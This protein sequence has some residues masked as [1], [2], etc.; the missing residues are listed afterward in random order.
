MDRCTC[1]C[2]C[3]VIEL[4]YFPLYITLQYTV[5]TI[6]WGH[7]HF[8][9]QIHIPSLAIQIQIGSLHITIKS[10]TELYI[11]TALVDFNSNRYTARITRR[12]RHTNSF[13]ILLYTY[14][15]IIHVQYYL[16]VHIRRIDAITTSDLVDLFPRVGYTLSF[17]GY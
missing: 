12:L 7:L 15:C 5:Y 2:S 9:L 1:S 3:C 16:S 11:D 6:V 8:A 14:I 13:S 4:F 17:A 10:F